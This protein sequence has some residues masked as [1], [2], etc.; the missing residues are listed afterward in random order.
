MSER[1]ER[2]SP[3]NSPTRPKKNNSTRTNDEE[4]DECSLPSCS[5]PPYYD[6]VTV[7]SRKSEAY[8]K[9]MSFLDEEAIVSTGGQLKK[10]TYD[11]ADD[12]SSISAS[13]SSPFKHS[14]SRSHSSKKY[15]WD[16]LDE[17]SEKS[18]ARNHLT[19]FKPPAYS[20]F[21]RESSVSVS[22]HISSLRS[23]FEELKE[24]VN[25]MKSELKLKGQVIKELQ[26]ELI[27]LK[28]AR[29]I[30]SAVICRSEPPADRKVDKC[31]AI[32]SKR[33]HNLKEDNSAAFKKQSDFVQ[34]VYLKEGA[35]WM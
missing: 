31:C 25:S 33:L 16:D 29:G 15:V 5:V 28:T 14:H 22:S 17:H 18:S 12:M 8:S 21:P 3:I 32:W 10:T 24:K 11:E 4:D 34:K 13:M 26:C 2:F 23:N 1:P 27:R 30:L 6:D 9:L 20:N 19:F 7:S 35:I